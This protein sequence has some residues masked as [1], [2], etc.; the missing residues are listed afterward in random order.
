LIDPSASPT[1]SDPRARV[2]LLLINPRFPESF[3]SFRWA[4]RNIL[5]DKR[6][7][8]PPLG[9]ATLAALCPPNWDVEI[10]DE[11]V[12]PVPLDPKA[13]LVGVCGMAVQFERQRELLEYYRGRG[14]P[15][16]AGGSFASLCPERYTRLAD[17]VVVGESEN[18]WP[19]FCRDFESGAPQALYHETGTV[20]I[21]QSP[22]PRFDLLKLD[23]Y[24]SVAMQFSRGCPFR[25]DFCDIIVM[26]GRQPRTKSAEQIG[27][28]LD[29][30]RAQGVR[31]VFFVDDNLIGN[32]KLAK[33]LLRY[34][35]DYQT[36]HNY[37]FRFG[38]E[39]SINLADDAEMLELL[40]AANFAWVFIGIESADEESLKETNKT[41]N[42]KRDLLAAIRT[43]YAHGIDVLAGFIVGFDNDTLDTFEK[44][45]RFISLSGIQVAMVGLLAA[46]PRTPLYER[47]QKEGRLLE[48]SAHGDNTK[49]GTNFL[50]KRMSYDAMVQNYQQLY[51]RLFSDRG[52]ARRI[53]NKTRYLRGGA[54]DEYSVREQLGIVCKLFSRGLLAGGPRRW[55][56]FL[57][58]LLT[59]RPRVWSQVFLDWIVGLSMRDYVQRH[60]TPVRASGRRRVQRAVTALQ[61]LCP[62]DLRR[63]A[64]EFIGSLGQRGANLQ[65]R[66]HGEMGRE[67]FHRAG[68]RLDKMLRNSSATLTLTI[69]ALAVEQREH[70]AGLLV[71]L[72]PYGDR[73]SIWISEHLRPLVTID[74]SVFHLLLAPRGRAA[75]R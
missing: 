25:C 11:N 28:E 48:E 42:M 7:L 55:F 51:R 8:N 67:F 52:I 20:D 66:F 34:L 49:L 62:A 50:P 18:I 21:Q 13:D 56:Y 75:L 12:E 59:S 65:I 10:I 69:D 58:N 68:R 15:V 39:A 41:Q 37:A 9:L 17:T 74:S 3:W 26:F 47:L 54:A 30:L 6:A 44:Q 27:R 43:I 31:S 23:R 19:E 70:L 38:T 72:A 33:Q 29:L 14:L 53:A 71:R 5:T 61:R 46:L 1:S 24:T 22:T 4:L 32:K 73:V 64:V 45:H 2:R 57:G 16:V 35:V 36:R 40:R 60:F 63:G